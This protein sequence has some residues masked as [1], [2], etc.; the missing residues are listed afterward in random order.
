MESQDWAL[1][2]E[3]M[4]I[5]SSPTFSFQGEK[6]KMNI[7]VPL[8]TEFYLHSHNQWDVFLY[9]AAT[10]QY[11]PLFKPTWL[12]GY[13]PPI[14]KSLINTEKQRFRTGNDGVEGERNAETKN[15]KEHLS[16]TAMLL[17]SFYPT[18]QSGFQ[19]MTAYVSP[20]AWPELHSESLPYKKNKGCLTG[21]L[22]PTV[23]KDGTSLAFP[24][25]LKRALR[26]EGTTRLG[27]SNAKKE[28]LYS[29]LKENCLQMRWRMICYLVS[30][31]IYK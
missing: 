5:I 7:K 1:L 2:Q 19:M 14:N 3:K 10:V 25:V 22:L 28:V 12:L 20:T 21:I 11:I 13:N 18:N 26:N 17:F 23:V 24:P 6:N 4:Q 29:A 30:L 9:L 16:C 8:W 27:Q 31:Q 15:G